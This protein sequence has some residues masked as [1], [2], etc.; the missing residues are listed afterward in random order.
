MQ[1]LPTQTPPIT[2]EESPAAINSAD[3]EAAN[4]HKLCKVWGFVKY[5]HLAFLTGEKDWD[6]ELLRLIPVIQTA[7]EDEVND[8]LYDWFNS[9]GDDGYDGHSSSYYAIQTKEF[10]NIS[11]RSSRQWKEFFEKIEELDWMYCDNTTERKTWLTYIIKVGLA[12][13]R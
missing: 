12:E 5:T 8:I 2:P 1:T 3:A 10:Q 11:A 7:A 9:L 6:E 13:W 4:L